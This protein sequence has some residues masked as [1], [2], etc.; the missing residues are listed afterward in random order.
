MPPAGEPHAILV[1]TRDT[2]LADALRRALGERGIEHRAGLHAGPPSRVVV[3]VPEAELGA[4]REALGELL[5]AGSHL[6]P[7]AA[8]SDAARGSGEEERPR[9]TALGAGPGA[10]PWLAVQ[11]VLGVVLAHLSLVALGA[12][13]PQAGRLLMRHGA[14]VAGLA[15]SEPWRLLTSLALHSD[16]P[17]ALWNGLSMLVFAV[18]LLTEL[19]SARTAL[20]YLLSGVGGG[21]TALAFAAPGEAVI[22]SSGAVAGLFGAW[23]VLALR[24]NWNAVPAWRARVRILGIA[25]LVL[26]TLLRPET[27]AGEPISVSSHVGGLVTGTL[28]GA[29]LAGG[30]LAG[31]RPVAQD[32]AGEPPAPI[33]P[34]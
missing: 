10:F 34:H 21:M 4:A 6:G 23:V 5:E 19:G 7:P 26:P 30:L 8:A 25:L 2:W 3:T 15:G 14:L 13:V 27:A 31:G 16:P 32:G 18:P 28:I 9:Q 12:A 29:A 1:E 24:T 20:I 17:H 22:G 11:Q 33:V